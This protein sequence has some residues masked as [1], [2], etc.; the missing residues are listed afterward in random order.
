[1]ERDPRLP[2]TE[3]VYYILLAL[4]L[5]AHGYLIMSRVEQMSGAQVKLAPGTLYGALANLLKQGLIVQIESDDPRRKVYQIT[6]AGTQLLGADT[7]RM[8]HMVSVFNSV[9]DGG[10]TR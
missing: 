9:Y 4:A 10:E 8:T 3:T 7:Q 5:P 1:M 2:L 6:T